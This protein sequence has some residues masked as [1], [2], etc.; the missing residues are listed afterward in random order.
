MR[1]CAIHQPNFFP[2]M[3]YFDKIRQADVFVLMDDVD[4]PK[5][6]S[7]GMGSWSNRVK[8]NIQGNAQWF[9]C[10]IDKKT[11]DKRI[12]DVLIAKD[13]KWR[14]KALKTLQLNYAKAQNFK[15]AMELIEP[16]INNPTHSLSDYNISS[17]T[18]ICK[19]LDIE[20]EFVI[21]SDL[22]TEKASTEVLIEI[23][24]KVGADAYLAGGGAGGYQE[25]DKFEAAGIKLVYQ[26]FKPEA[27]GP[28]DKFIPGLSVLDYLMHAV[29]DEQGFGS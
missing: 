21:Q 6:G 19:A 5:S 8:I 20:S 11:G 15:P 26:D 1:L 10:P 12:K 7:G 16:L 3:G 28:E 24:Q 14:R 22:Q 2:W 9:G 4:Y 29:L 18:T 13:P 25:D 27:Y 17:I 23:C